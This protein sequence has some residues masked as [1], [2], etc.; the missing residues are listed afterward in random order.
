[1]ARQQVSW[2]TGIFLVV[3]TIYE[4]VKKWFQIPYF[5][6]PPKTKIELRNYQSLLR[7]VFAHF[8]KTLNTT[9]NE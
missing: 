1:M 7:F 3:T 5:L 8:E 2:R 9:E 4:L 6:K